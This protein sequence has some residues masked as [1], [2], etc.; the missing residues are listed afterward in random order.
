MISTKTRDDIN[1][2]FVGEKLCPSI[3]EEVI[4]FDRDTEVK[5]I[6]KKYKLKIISIE[7]LIAY[8]LKNESLIRKDLEV[9][10][11]TKFGEFNL[12]AYTQ[13]NTN[14]E[15]LAIIKGKWN[16]DEPVLTRVHSSCFTGDILGSLRCDCGDQLA[17]A[18]QQIEKEQLQH[19]HKQ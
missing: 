1:D 13:T 2:H 7:D 12:I 10:M 6:A 3:A 11:P 5:K 4:S 17:L 14:E 9:K 16:K 19:R 18:L 8:R 15:H